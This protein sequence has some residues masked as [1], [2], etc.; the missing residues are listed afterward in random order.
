ML[1]SVYKQKP[2]TVFQT[3][4]T[5]LGSHQ[6]SMKV[7]IVSHILQQLLLL[8]FNVFLF[9]QM[10]G[11]FNFSLTSISLS[12][13]TN[14]IRHI[15]MSV[16]AI[17]DSSFVK[18]LCSLLSSLLLSPTGQAWSPATSR[19]SAQLDPVKGIRGGHP[20][21]S[22]ELLPK[23]RL[24]GSGCPRITN[25][26][27]ILPLPQASILLHFALSKCHPSFKP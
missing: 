21:E 11:G 24:N 19:A 8:S 13:M 26:D 14:N 25:T 5:V 3:S 9:W 23:R 10:H 4:C 7:L 12:L 18:C 2:P 22:R 16:F 20:K 6:Q 17:A 1:D 27:D 15:F